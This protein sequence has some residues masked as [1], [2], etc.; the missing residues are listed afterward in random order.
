MALTN[1]NMCSE[2]TNLKFTDT[3][4]GKH[5]MNEYLQLDSSMI[6]IIHIYNNK[7]N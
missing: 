4:V 7:Y 3:S 6:H 2:Q 1:E 5:A